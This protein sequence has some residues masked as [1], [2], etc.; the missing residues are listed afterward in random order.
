[1]RWKISSVKIRKKQGRNA[2]ELPVTSIMAQT[3]Y[4][5]GRNKLVS[6]RE[7]INTHLGL[8]IVLVSN[9]N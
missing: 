7:K 8:C 2:G 3:Y 9:L 5:T 1:M 6:E 4:F